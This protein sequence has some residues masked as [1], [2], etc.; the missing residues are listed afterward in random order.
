MEDQELWDLMGDLEDVGLGDSQTKAY[1]IAGF[2]EDWEEHL[3]NESLT[4]NL[5]K[6][7]IEDN[8]ADGVDL[9]YDSLVEPKSP[10]VDPL[11]SSWFGFADK[12]LII[13][14]NF[15]K[16]RLA[17]EKLRK[18]FVI[19]K[20]VE[21]KNYKKFESRGI[22]GSVGATG[23]S[24]TPG[25]VGATGISGTPG[26]YGATGYA[27]T[28]TVVYSSPGASGSWSTSGVT[29]SVS[30]PKMI[31]TSVKIEMPIEEL[32]DL[33]DFSENEVETYGHPLWEKIK[34]KLGF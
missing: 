19:E 30:T 12:Y 3:D 29:V 1:L 10:H 18:D 2:Y 13:K 7:F 15:T 24:G 16:V 17:E 6:S 31:Q 26:S 14:G 21:L 34:G 9:F 33:K 11:I 5:V 8:K 4:V 22:S 28:T 25:S 20:E 27:G 23:I 32:E